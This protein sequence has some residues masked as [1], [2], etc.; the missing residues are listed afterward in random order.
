MNMN[1]RLLALA[2]VS[3]ATYTQDAVGLKLSMVLMP[4]SKAQPAYESPCPSYGKATTVE[5][6]VDVG[7]APSGTSAPKPITF[8]NRRDQQASRH[9]Q[10]QAMH[11][12]GRPRPGVGRKGK[13]LGLFRS[14]HERTNGLWLILA[15]MVLAGIMGGIGGSIELN[16]RQ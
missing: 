9:R 13:I 4:A 1:F 14:I 7:A 10:L 12:A 5:P 16:Q 3:G 8:I 15:I 11:L 2:T 6:A